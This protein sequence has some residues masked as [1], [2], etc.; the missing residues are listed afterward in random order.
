MR[1]LIYKQPRR[2]IVRA[3]DVN[4]IRRFAF[5]FGFAEVSEF[6][7]QRGGRNQ[8]PGEQQTSE[9]CRDWRRA[10]RLS[11]AANHHWAA[12]RSTNHYWAAATRP[13][14]TDLPGED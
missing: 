3:G 10:A 1:L 13:A 14:T 2:E 4:H 9:I 6:G 5:G 11:I 12:T 8:Q 7:L